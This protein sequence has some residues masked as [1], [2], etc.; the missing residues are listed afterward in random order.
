MIR[1]IDINQ[2][3]F[4]PAK[5]IAV[6]AMAL[7]TWRIAGWTPL[8]LALFLSFFITAAMVSAPRDS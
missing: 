3:S 8:A 2:A 6:I 4:E 1:K 7:G 5:W